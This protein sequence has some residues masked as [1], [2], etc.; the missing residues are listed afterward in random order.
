MTGNQVDEL[1]LENALEHEIKAA[2]THQWLRDDMA[3]EDRLYV[4]DNPLIVCEDM[5]LTHDRTEANEHGWHREYSISNL[6][7]LT[8]GVIIDECRDAFLWS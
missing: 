4:K 8:P 5:Y 2:L 1:W 3:F 7:N 6:S